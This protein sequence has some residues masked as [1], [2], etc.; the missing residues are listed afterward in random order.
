M[1]WSKNHIDQKIDR[2]TADLL[3]EYGLRIAKRII[4]Q[5]KRNLA[6]EQKRRKNL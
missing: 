3:A 6:A 4:S 1:K 5:V 2:L